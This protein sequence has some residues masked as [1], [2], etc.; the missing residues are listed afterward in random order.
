[1]R[2]CPPGWATDL[3]ILEHTGSVVEDHD[4][5][6]VVRTAHNPGFHWGNFLL[7]TDDGSVDDA[8]R[9]VDAFHRAFPE[10][11]WVAIGLAR[12]PDDRDAWVAH[13]LELELDEVLTTSTVPR[14]TPLADGYTVRRFDGPDWAASLDRT[15]ARNDRTGD[16]DPSSFVPYVRRQLE[17]RRELSRRDVGAWFGA[18]ADDVLVADLGIV[19]CGSTARYQDVSTDEQHQRRG[20]ASHLLGVAAQWSAEGG[21]DR[22]VIVTEATNPAGRVYRAVGFAPDTGAV[23]AYRRPP[24]E[25]R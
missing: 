13:G 1:M 2:T 18:F 6:L 16:E 19:R 12:M 20:L 4:D 14:R 17:A 23:Q 22:W 9:W 8:Q 15:L 24:R 5:H 11:R 21:C 3:A 25:V 10:A 7:V